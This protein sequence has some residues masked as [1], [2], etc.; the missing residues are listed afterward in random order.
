MYHRQAKNGKGAKL[1]WPRGISDIRLFRQ[2]S[3]IHPEGWI[4]KDSPEERYGNRNACQD[5]DIPGSRRDA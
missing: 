3:R 4:F 2:G 1:T 5:A